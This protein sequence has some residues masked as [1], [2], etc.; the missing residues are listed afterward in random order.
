MQSRAGILAVM[1]KQLLEPAVLTTVRKL[2]PAPS[3]SDI[4]IALHSRPW[5]NL[6]TYFQSNLLVDRLSCVYSKGQLVARNAQF[7][8]AS[9]DV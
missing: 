3:K 4:G 1:R 6:R 5:H 9:G 8:C 2:Q 7:L